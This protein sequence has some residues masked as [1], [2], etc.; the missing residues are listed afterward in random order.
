MPRLMLEHMLY[1]IRSKALSWIVKY[2]YIITLF[3]NIYPSIYALPP[4]N[5]CQEYHMQLG[6]TSPEKPNLL[7][8]I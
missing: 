4:S 3:L 6:T 1:D 7:T 5:P 2:E 8:G